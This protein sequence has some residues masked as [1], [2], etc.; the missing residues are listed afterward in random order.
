M[1]GESREP[2]HFHT[3][4]KI[5]FKV[6]DLD[7]Y[8]V[9]KCDTCGHFLIMFEDGKGCQVVRSATGAEEALIIGIATVGNL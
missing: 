7:E 4:N 5:L 2:K 3:T 9:S 1:V 8:G 6:G